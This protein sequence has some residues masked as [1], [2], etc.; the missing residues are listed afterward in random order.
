[1]TQALLLGCLGAVAWGCGSMLS[2]PS[3]RILGVA[4]SVLWLS[5]AST[6][7]GAVLALLIGGAPRV[8]ARDVP[9]L[10]LA[11]LMLFAATNL[12]ALLMRRSDVSMATPIVACDGA[13]A[14]S[15][16]VLAGHRLPTVAYAGLAAMV[17]GLL[18]L[19]RQR[20]GRQ[21]NAI[22]YDVER[23]FSTRATVAIAALTAICY[24]A[25][26]FFTGQVDA[27]PALWTATIVRGSVT[28]VALAL[29][30]APRASRPPA[31]GLRFAVAAGVLDVT[32]FGLYIT[33]ARHDLAVAAVAVSQYG[34]VA[35]L[36]SMLYLR[37][38]LTRAQWS[39]TA[40]LI[41]GAALVAA[42]GR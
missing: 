27:T 6:L 10:G 29:T 24:G 34:A 37:E 8:A 1:M 36:A 19:S 30:A 22:R 3:S 26:F 35:V 38:R 9:Y 5:V 21:P 42:R 2:A 20:S 13:V 40:V 14:A 33:G 25:L 39:G 12:W 41:V 18:V 23:R 17:T 4:G 7:A 28:L 15:I 11:A 16:A 32:G 31:A